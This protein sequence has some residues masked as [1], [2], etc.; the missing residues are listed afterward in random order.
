MNSP[1]HPEEPADLVQSRQWMDGRVPGGDCRVVCGQVTIE[2]T[3][4]VYGH[5]FVGRHSFAPFVETVAQAN[6]D[7]GIGFPYL[8]GNM[9]ANFDDVTDRFPEAL[10]GSVLASR[11]DV[12]SWASPMAHLDARDDWHS[13]GVDVESWTDVVRLEIDTRMPAGFTFGPRRARR[14]NA[15]VPPR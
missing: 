1:L 6:Y 11:G 3:P 15:L 13:P 2:G 12:S 7:I 5:T 14:L 9:A 4:Y 8:E 10:Q